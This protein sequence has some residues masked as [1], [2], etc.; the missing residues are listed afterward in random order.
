MEIVVDTNILIAALLKDSK[1]RELIVNSKNKLLVPEITF[2][3]IEEHKQ[4]LLYKTGFSEAEF[5]LLIS[6]ISEYL[7]IIKNE[8]IINYQ[9]QAE[10]I[11]GL[12][13]KNDIPIIAT[14]LAYNECPIWSDDKH[15][16]QQKKYCELY[17]DRS[18]PFHSVFYLIA[19]A[20]I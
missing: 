7:L 4:E 13:D 11:I 16:Q 1:I 2:Q 19:I 20:H 10:S 8:E 3:E 14:S 18:R 15:F 5:N 17:N 12:I 9:E 6:K